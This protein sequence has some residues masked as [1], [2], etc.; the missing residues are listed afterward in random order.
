MFPLLISLPV[1]RYHSNRS[2]MMRSFHIFGLVWSLF[3]FI[4]YL[5]V[6]LEGMFE[7]VQTDFRYSLRLSF[8]VSTVLF[9]Y[10]GIFSVSCWI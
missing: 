8:S 5:H 10:Y 4:P 2:V 3:L 7:L 9:L 1:R 6:E